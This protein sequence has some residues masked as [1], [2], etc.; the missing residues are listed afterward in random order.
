MGSKKIADHWDKLDNNRVKCGLCPHFCTIEAKKTGKCGVRENREGSLIAAS[1]GCVTSIALDPIEKKPLY[2][3]YPGKKIVSIGSYGCNLKCQF[4][5]NYGISMEY[6]GMKTEIMTPEL[7]AQVAQLS[8]KDGN[9]GVAYT[10]NE[11]LIGYEFVK[12]CSILIR[13]EGLANVLVTNGYINNEPLKELLQHIDALNIDIKGN[14]NRTYSK[15][16]GTLEPVKNTIEIA[17]KV[18][19]VEVTTLVVP[20]ENDNEIEEIAKWLSEINPSIPYHLSRFF[21]RY[22]YSESAATPPELM[23]KLKER[24]EKYLETV[25]LGNM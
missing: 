18:C 7:V 6:H 24:A 9:V 15:L 5:Q 1:Y 12:D 8:I 2:N 20:N 16:G 17:N 22:K 10:Y 3:F 11:P 23:Y 13:K 19:H 14:N 21:P 25:Y 4:C